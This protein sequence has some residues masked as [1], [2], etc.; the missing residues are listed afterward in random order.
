MNELHFAEITKA[1][2]RLPHWAMEKAI[3]WVT[4]RLADGAAFFN[5]RF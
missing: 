4:F 3:H 5:R 1:H 2:R